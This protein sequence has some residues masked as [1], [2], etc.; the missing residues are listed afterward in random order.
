MN[1]SAAE[2]TGMLYNKQCCWRGSCEDFDLLLEVVLEL[3]PLTNVQLVCPTTSACPRLC[4]RVWSIFVYMFVL[5]VSVLSNGDG[6]CPG[7]SSSFGT[8]GNMTQ[9]DAI[10][11]NRL[12]PA[13]Q[14]THAQENIHTENKDVQCLL[15]FVV[16]NFAIDKHLDFIVLQSAVCV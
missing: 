12:G 14:E 4:T 11:P 5:C 3:S 6:K 15:F 13:A 16:V 7:S 9:M 8:I 1:E 2:Q 10:S